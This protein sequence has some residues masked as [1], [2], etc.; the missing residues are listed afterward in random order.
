MSDSRR[1]LSHRGQ[2]PRHHQV[3]AQGHQLSEIPCHQHHTLGQPELVGLDRG[4]DRDGDRSAGSRDHLAL[5][6]ADLPRRVEHV[7]GECIDHAGADQLLARNPE[8]PGHSL[9]QRAD[10]TAEAECGDPVGDRLQDLRGEALGDQK[11]ASVADEAHQLECGQAGEGGRAESRDVHTEGG[12]DRV[13]DR[14]GDQRTHQADGGQPPRSALGP[15]GCAPQ[16]SN[17]AVDG[18]CRRGD[19]D[20]VE[21]RKGGPGRRRISPG[22]GDGPLDHP[23]GG[24]GEHQKESNDRVECADDSRHSAIR[25]PD[26]L[27]HYVEGEGPEANPSE[28][29]EPLKAEGGVRVWRQA[30]EHLA[31]GPER[32]RQ[33]QRYHGED[34]AI[35]SRA[36]PERDRDCRGGNA[37]CQ[38]DQSVRVHRSGLLPCRES[39]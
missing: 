23:R 6:L 14:G 1:E 7:L 26:R 37:G 18:G 19:G 5:Q 24:P 31:E 32:A 12:Q 10:V 17:P 38:R 39:A 16:M 28:G 30:P 4:R 29:R 2:A 35:R 15:L 11:R 9:V 25:L 3:V 36:K 8:E 21:D 22:G 27:V 34:P 13:G 20:G 33:H